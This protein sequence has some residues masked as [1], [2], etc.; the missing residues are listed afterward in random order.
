MLTKLLKKN[1]M[2]KQLYRFTYWLLRLPVFWFTPNTEATNGNLPITVLHQVLPTE[3]L[4]CQWVYTLQPTTHCASHPNPCLGKM[5]ISLGVAS[6]LS[7]CLCSYISFLDITWYVIINYQGLPR[8]T[9]LHV[10][11]SRIEKKQN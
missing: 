2:Y 9:K 5:N 8:G 6:I 11:I 4:H 1:W 3:P 10:S 7:M